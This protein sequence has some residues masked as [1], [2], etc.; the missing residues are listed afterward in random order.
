MQSGLS[1]VDRRSQAGALEREVT[2]V[3]R[4]R[5]SVR[6]PSVQAES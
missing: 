6:F 4:L 3:P 5:E 1:P 2:G